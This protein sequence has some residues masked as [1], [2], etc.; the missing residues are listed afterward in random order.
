MPLSMGMLS[1][2]AVAP[3]GWL[4]A[5]YGDRVVE[6]HIDRD[7]T[8]IT[9]TES[10]D[11]RI[12]KM[13]FVAPMDWYFSSMLVVNRQLSF[14]AKVNALINLSEED[15]TTGGAGKSIEV[16][17]LNLGGLGRASLRVRGNV[18]IS[19]KM[20]FQD[21]QLVASSVKENNN[22]HLEFDQKQ[23]LNIEGKIGDR[24]TVKMDQDS[25]RDFDWENNIRITYDGHE[26]DIIQKVEAGN[27]SLSLP[28]TQYVTFSGSN[29]GLFGLKAISKLGPLDITTIASIEQTKKEQQSYK[30]SNEKKTTVIKDN[31][32]VK[33]QHFII[34][35]WFRNGVNSDTI[36]YYINDDFIIPPYYPLS[37]EGYHYVGNVK[38]VDFELYKSSTSNDASIIPGIAYRDALAQDPTGTVQRNFIRM[39]RNVD[40]YI[41][42]DYGYLRLNQSAYNV[43][44]GCTFSLIL[45]DGSN[46]ER[47]ITIGHGITETDSVLALKMIKPIS[48]SYADTK[49]W[50][51]MLKNIYNLGTSNIIQEGFEVRIVNTNSATVTD[52]FRDGRSFLTLFGL[53]RQGK[54]GEGTP[55]D[56]LIDLDNANIISLANGELVLPFYHPF[57]VDTV[58]GGNPNEDLQD[59]LGNGDMYFNT[60]QLANADNNFV[61]EADYTNPS[62]TISLGFMLVEGSEEIKSMR[63]NKTEGLTIKLTISP[64]Q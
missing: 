3:H 30:G 22:T 55:S 43:E 12:V 10:I 33:D 62:S 58:E 60:A 7:W 47:L 15:K 52:R 36:P 64:G 29:K 11:G 13:P 34:H 39:E 4:T 44:L 1:D 63:Q 19:G 18:N 16:V 17:G 9:L 50:P 37:Q 41:S 48:S 5:S 23:N 14:I 35:E 54:N 45:R 59:L 25:E 61:I 40:Y 26:D 57:A 6:I 27:I 21:Q 53:D 8:T 46:K 31:Q 20:V 32:Y 56:D 51:L 2:T 49:T 38:I 28:A 42:P 24:I